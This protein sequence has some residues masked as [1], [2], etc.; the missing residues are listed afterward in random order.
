MV[1]L[2][3]HQ[4]WM[5]FADLYELDAQTKIKPE[6]LSTDCLQTIIQV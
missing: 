5:T 3:G 2:G 4:A 6:Q 1:W